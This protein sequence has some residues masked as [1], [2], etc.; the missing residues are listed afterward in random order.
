M[1]RHFN[2][3]S[4]RPTS[5]ESQPFSQL[6]LVAIIGALSLSACSKSDEQ[7]ASNTTATQ[8]TNSVADT[9]AAEPVAVTTEPAPEVKVVEV[10]N[11]K[12]EVEVI[13]TLKD[14]PLL[15]AGRSAASVLSSFLCCGHFQTLPNK[16]KHL[17]TLPNNLLRVINYAGS[18]HGPGR[19]VADSGNNM[20]TT[21]VSDA[22]FRHR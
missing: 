21:A 17:L 2:Y 18:M 3:L 11:P 6:L 15:P 7:N 16:Y 20:A 4:L 9:Q 5:L 13:G 8:T 12:P 1:K 22:S 19:K 10:D 14:C